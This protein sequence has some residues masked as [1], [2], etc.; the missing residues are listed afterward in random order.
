MTTESIY[1]I[2]VRSWQEVFVL[3]DLI[4]EW[5]ILNYVFM[6]FDVS[7]AIISRYVEDEEVRILLKIKD[8]RERE[9]P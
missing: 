3:S 5:N 1:M 2:I 8:Y 7:E 6:N 4:Y 9:S